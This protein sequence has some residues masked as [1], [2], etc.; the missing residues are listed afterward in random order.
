MGKPDFQEMICRP[1]CRFFKQGVKEDLACQGALVVE[2]LLERGLISLSDMPSPKLKRPALWQEPDA[3]L[4]ATVCGRC[5]FRVD[6]CDFRASAPP[7]AAEPCGGYVMLR[8]IRAA[9]TLTAATL[10]EVADG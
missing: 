5:P 7:A 9:G 6:G 8:A 2:R 1:F 3:L 4:E 10:A